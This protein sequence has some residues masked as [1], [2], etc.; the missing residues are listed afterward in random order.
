MHSESFYRFWKRASVIR[1]TLY[2]YNFSFLFL[3]KTR[4]QF[5]L[6]SL[7]PELYSGEVNNENMTCSF[8]YIVLRNLAIIISVVIRCYPLG[9]DVTS[10]AALFRSRLL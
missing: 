1:M 3:L 7:L 8:I 6:K 4:V 9:I 5:F 10:P 2:M